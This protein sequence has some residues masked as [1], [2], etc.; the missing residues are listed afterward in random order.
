MSS[1]KLQISDGTTTKSFISG[2]NM[3]LVGYEP[4]TSVDGGLITE[5][6]RVNFTSQ[7]PATNTANINTLNK[8]FL[9]ARNYARTETGAKVYAGL[10]PGTSGTVWRSR[11]FDGSIRFNE[12]VL[13]KQYDQTIMAE[14]EWTRQP[15]WEGALTQIPLTN[16]S[17][18]DDTDGITISNRSDGGTA[19]VETA[20]IVGTIGP[21]GAGTATVT[22]TA[23]G[24][25]GSPL[26]TVVDLA[27]DDTPTISA[28]KMAT[29]MNLVSAITDRFNVSSS[30]ADLI[31]TRL[32]PEANDG[33]LNIAYANTT[34][35]DLVDD[36][37]SVDTTAG[38]ATDHEN[39]VSIKA[40]NVVGDLP[41]PIKLQLY[42]SKDADAADEFYVFHNVYSTPASLD[43]VLEGEDATGAT[44]TAVADGTSSDGFYGSLSYTA[45]VETLIATWALSTTELTYMAGGRFAILARWAAD[46]PYTDMS[47]RLKLEGT[48]SV[49][50][51]GNLN[52]ILDTRQLHL[53]DT[54][55]LPPYL[56][57]QSA[58]KGIN[59]KLYA[60]RNESGAHTIKLDYLQLS[61]ISGQ[62]GWKRF[63]SVDNGV[64]YQE[65]FT[66]DDTE[67]ITYRTD[68][69][70]KIIAEFA[71]Y[72]GP[73]MLVPGAVQKLY[74]TSCDYN[75]DAHVDQT[76]TTKLWYRPRRSSF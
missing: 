24:L 67:G 13:G 25:A 40:A 54:M 3:A 43:H 10:D 55:R 30:G 44:V 39:W 68:T 45:T 57:G 56:A 23:T 53:L 48:S 17:A 65:Y 63:L 14:I 37:T 38:S 11:L 61:P 34:T 73:I 51:T 72:G 26:A 27:N 6:F 52:P 20:T 33:D 28:G 59:L 5:R 35:S 66:H 29:A 21:A 70:S 22:L 7:T 32:V 62:G 36:P 18:T 19:Q 42:N 46:F 58:L 12:K 49:L 71:N 47:L 8:L 74:M 50:W 16:A 75:G 76:W 2:D 1:H 15:F 64:A 31:V 60:L 4:I 41:A 9:Q 69:S